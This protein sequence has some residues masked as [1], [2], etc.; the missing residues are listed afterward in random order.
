MRGLDRLVKLVFSDLSPMA[1]EDVADEGELVR[2]RAGTPDA[3]AAYPCCGAETAR[4]HGHH[5]RT[6]AVSVVVRAGAMDGTVG[7]LAVRLGGGPACEG[8]DAQQV[9]AVVFVKVVDLEGGVADGVL[10]A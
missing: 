10:L 6:L 3:R 2:V 9:V 4:V 5:E 1:V 8:G 7:V